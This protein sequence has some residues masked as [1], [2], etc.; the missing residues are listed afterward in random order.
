MIS[1]SVVFSNNSNLISE[2]KMAIKSD[3]LRQLDKKENQQL[4]KEWERELV[5]LI[6][7]TSVEKSKAFLR[8]NTAKA[9][10]DRLDSFAKDRSDVF[11]QSEHLLWTQS[12][13]W[14]INKILVGGGGSLHV[15]NIVKGKLVAGL[16][17]VGFLPITIIQENQKRGV[18]CVIYGNSEVWV[19]VSGGGKKNNVVHEA[20]GLW[21]RKFLALAKTKGGPEG[22]GTFVEDLISGCQ[23]FDDI[24]PGERFREIDVRVMKTVPQKLL[25]IADSENRG[26]KGWILQPAVRIKE[27]HRHNEKAHNI[28]L[29][30]LKEKATKVL[31]VDE[32]MTNSE[33][34][35]EIWVVNEKNWPMLERWMLGRSREAL[36]FVNA[37]GLDTEGQGATTQ[38]SYLSKDGI[39]SFLFLGYWV[40]KS[41]KDDIWDKSCF[42][43]ED[44]NDFSRVFCSTLGSIKLLCPALIAQDLPN[45]M[46][47]DHG[48]G[49]LARNILKLDVGEVKKAAKKLKKSS[50]SGEK[51]SGDELKLA[52]IRWKNWGASVL[53]P[54]KAPYAVVDSEVQLLS[55]LELA[56]MFLDVLLL[57]EISEPL[58][59]EDLMQR[60]WVSRGNL[61]LDSSLVFSDSP[62]CLLRRGLQKS[63]KSFLQFKLKHLLL[64]EI[65]KF[66][67]FFNLKASF[68]GLS[69]SQCKKERVDECRAKTRAECEDFVKEKLSVAK[70]NYKGVK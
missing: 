30:K 63:K 26:L 57:K 9:M 13:V 55:G 14:D 49:G 46:K 27:K 47:G 38:I 3:V 66:P 20:T 8:F 60:L 58:A 70:K 40:P 24:L 52:G 50:K 54:D 51:L 44:G 7:R 43:F 35:T 36:S 32:K 6:P 18:W 65:V 33:C 42:I 1:F 39:V 34:L 59:I 31:E 41:I 22:V 67:L 64:L 37:V 19:S 5:G 68:R 15:N 2:I 16:R 56:R 28:Q 11:S 12:L 17:R 53:K 21:I 4:R 45:I 25:D 48:V 10:K 29:E 23:A 69:A 61:I 62:K